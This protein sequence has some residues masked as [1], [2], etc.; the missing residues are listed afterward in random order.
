[1]KARSW[2][3]LSLL[4]LLLSP[5][6][7]RAQEGKVRDLAS[8]ALNG[9]IGKI[10]ETVYLSHRFQVDGLK[11]LYAEKTAL[12]GFSEYRFDTSGRMTVCRLFQQTPY[13]DQY[14]SF[15]FDAAHRLRACY[16]GAGGVP[17]GREEFVY[18]IIGQLSHAR[19]YDDT[20]GLFCET[21]YRYH[22]K[23]LLEEV[24]YNRQYVEISR[25]KYTYDSLKRLL[26]EES[27]RN[28]Y[29]YNVA[30]TKR[31]TYDAKGHAVRIQYTEKSGKK[32]WDYR[33]RF[34]ASGRIL[35]ES[36]VHLPDSVDK[37]REYTYDCRHR[38][39]KEVSQDGRIKQQKRY[40]YDRKGR[41][42]YV[43]NQFGDTDFRTFYRQYDA[44]GNW[45]EK[46]DYDG[47]NLQ[48]TT[49]EITYY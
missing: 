26:K 13:R 19:Q 18:N 21:V 2:L 12:T 17:Q 14:D 46:V 37:H 28:P 27:L 31:Y 45:T 40:R 6:R 42:L 41:L 22:D 15:A 32:Q 34:D 1:M 33:C 7:A 10:K 24:T 36:T 39:V 44:E 16:W 9:K 29:K 30:Y 43:R 11:L 23:L 38:L 5:A 20:G 3:L 48:V 25:V 35:S 4:C 8:M 47:I 49:R